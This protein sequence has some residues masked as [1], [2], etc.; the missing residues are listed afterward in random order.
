VH[1][2]TTRSKAQIAASKLTEK[3]YNKPVMASGELTQHFWR[4]RGKPGETPTSM[5]P[6]RDFKRVLSEHKLW[7][8]PLDRKD[9]STLC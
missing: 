5:Q 9:S 6:C 2:V 8:S 3:M 4:Q 7:T 1:Y